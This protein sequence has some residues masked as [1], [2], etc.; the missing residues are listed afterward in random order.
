MC[1]HIT[2]REQLKTVDRTSVEYLMSVFN[3]THA[4]YTADRLWNE[5]IRSTDT[6]LMSSCYGYTPDEIDCLRPWFE[7][8]ETQANEYN[9]DLGF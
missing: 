9:P 2:T 6:V 7:R 1:N 3:P 5:G 4:K 8:W